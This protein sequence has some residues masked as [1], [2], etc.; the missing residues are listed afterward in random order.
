MP[1]LSFGGAK[2]VP[3]A[4]LRSPGMQFAFLRSDPVTGQGC[5]LLVVQLPLWLIW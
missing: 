4:L 5:L 1:W 3:G 2:P